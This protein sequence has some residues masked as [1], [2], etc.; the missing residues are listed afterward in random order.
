[1]KKNLQWKVLGTI[2]ISCVALYFVLTKPIS[3]GIDLAGGTHFT[4]G[5]VTDGLSDEKKQE[6][7]EQTLA[8]YRN[9]ID[10]IGASKATS[11]VKSSTFVTVMPS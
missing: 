10:E 3:K 11:T 7:M 5:V 4:I 8:V 9:R 6:V 1:M 2:V